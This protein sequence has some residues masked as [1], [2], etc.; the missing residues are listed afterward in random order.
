MNTS[1]KIAVSFQKN[2]LW[3]LKALGIFAA[4]FAAA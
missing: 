2:S 3:V 4:A 1:A